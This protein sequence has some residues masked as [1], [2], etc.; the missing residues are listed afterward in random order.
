MTASL[1]QRTIAW[2]IFPLLFGWQLMA[3]APSKLENQVWPQIAEL[4]MYNRGTEPLDNQLAAGM[5]QAV[6]AGIQTPGISIITIDEPPTSPDGQPLALTYD[7][8][9][10]VSEGICNSDAIVFAKVESSS[11]H[12]SRDRSTLFTDYQME[13]TDVL[14]QNATSPI[15]PGESLILTRFGGQLKLTEGELSVEDEGAPNLQTDE[16]Y[17]IFAKFVRGVGVYQ[18][19]Y[20]NGTFRLL[21]RGFSLYRKALSLEELKKMSPSDVLSFIGSSLNT[22]CKTK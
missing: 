10:I 4:P 2:A 15:S 3:T 9:H 17:I 13:V 11:S 20:L 12:L 22:N 19:L 14:K 8:N 5:E 1:N 18:S 7:L 16:S 6:V 21:S